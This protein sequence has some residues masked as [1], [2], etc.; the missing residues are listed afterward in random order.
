MTQHLFQM[1]SIPQ[2]DLFASHLNHQLPLWFCWT[3]HPL[4]A[5]SNALSQ[6]WTGLSLYAYPPIRLLE[7]TLIKI[8]KDQAEEAVVITPIG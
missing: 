5:A 7:R 1:W 2:V 8:R 6:L 3:D 4:V